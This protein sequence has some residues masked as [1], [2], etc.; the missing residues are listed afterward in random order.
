MILIQ[1][2]LAKY[3]MVI[4]VSSLGLYD[5]LLW[6]NGYSTQNRGLAGLKGQTL[7]MWLVN[8]WLTDLLQQKNKNLGDDFNNF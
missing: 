6:F 2:C 4:L 8:D 5:E 7:Y 3:L 1:K